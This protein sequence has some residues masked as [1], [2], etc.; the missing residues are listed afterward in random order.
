[1][2]RVWNINTVGELA[3]EL[4]VKPQRILNEA[5]RRGVK[6]AGVND[7]VPRQVAAW[8]REYFDIV[9]PSH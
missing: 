8:I 1:M 6:L 5:P 3:D 4:N 2:D 9:D 7:K